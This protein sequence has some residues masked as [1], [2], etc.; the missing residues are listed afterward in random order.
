MLLYE[1]LTC[2]ALF[3]QERLKRAAALE[4]R[5][6]LCEKELPKPST[7]L[8][9]SI[10]RQASIPAQRNTET[11]K[12]GKLVRGDLHGIVM[13]CLEKHCNR[14]YEIANGMI[15]D[16]ERYLHDELVVTRP[17][18]TWYPFNLPGTHS[19]SLRDEAK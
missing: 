14:C 15:R 8:N 10:D 9:L 18:S 16:I 17:L 13:K 1:L 4:I 7:R 19:T 5:R 6:I 12:R 11:T 2:T 3:D